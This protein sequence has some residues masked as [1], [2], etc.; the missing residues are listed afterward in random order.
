MVM[1]DYLPLSQYYLYCG[2]CRTYYDRWKYSSLE[3]SGHSKCRVRTLNGSE[4]LL[5]LSEDREQGCLE[6]KFLDSTVQRR[7]QRLAELAQVLCRK[8][9]YRI[10]GD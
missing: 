8:K 7:G 6:E 1:G 5:M 4:Y 2:S 3:D 9:G 10:R